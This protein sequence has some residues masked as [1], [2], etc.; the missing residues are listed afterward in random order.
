MGNKVSLDYQRM[1]DFLKTGKMELENYESVRE[2]LAWSILL[3]VQR[4]GEVCRENGVQP[5]DMGIMLKSP[6][7]TQGKR[8]LNV[9]MRI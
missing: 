7:E 9:T 4:I 3:C 2:L 1:K 8:Y 6:L 5:E